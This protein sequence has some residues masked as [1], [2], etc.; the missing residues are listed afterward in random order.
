[1]GN[2][3]E[4]DTCF[5]YGG[6]EFMLLLAQTSSEG[7]QKVGERIRRLCESTAYNNG[8]YDKTVTVSVGI[9]CLKQK[10][11]TRP[12]DMLA[13]ADK[14]L[15]RAKAEGRNR[16][17]VY[18]EASVDRAKQTDGSSMSLSFLK[19]RLAAILD[20]T[21]KA[22]IETLELLV[23]DMRTPGSNG[24]NHRVVQYLE[25]IGSRLGLPPSI[26]RTLQRAAALHDCTKVLL[27]QTAASQRR[28]LNDEELA[29]IKDHPSM[30]AELIKPFDFFSN[31]RAAL[32]YHHEKF[33]GTGYPEGL[34]GDQIPLGARVFSI[35]DAIVAMTSDRPY[36]PKLSGEQLVQELVDNAGTQFDPSLVRIFIDILSENDL[37][38]V[39]AETLSAAREKMLADST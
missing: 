8:E 39:P 12:E 32:L 17:E 36:R 4:S 37:I 25:L 23:N 15:Y 6:E 14:A 30:L 22:S 29:S 26:I 38:K 10:D 31:E 28:Q 34:K 13:Y 20:K 27:S 35:A 24:H 9:S 2:V 33:D 3:R 1:M 21:K 16:L 11:L 7:A 19:D 18:R 5:R